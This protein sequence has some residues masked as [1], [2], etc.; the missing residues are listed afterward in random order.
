MAEAVGVIASAITVAQL[1]DNAIKLRRLWR[2]G[3][4]AG[5][6]LTTLADD[7]DSLSTLLIKVDFQRQDICTDRCSETIWHRCTCSCQ[8]VVTELAV[9]VKDLE[10]K[11][12]KNRFKA[13][14]RLMAE[15]DA[16]SDLKMRL[17]AAKSTL[18]MA[19][20]TYLRYEYFL[21]KIRESRSSKLTVHHSVR[22]EYLFQTQSKELQ[23]LRAAFTEAL[24]S[25]S[26]N[27]YPQSPSLNVM[28]T[29]RVADARSLVKF[30]MFM[31]PDASQFRWPRKRRS[32]RT[33]TWVLGRIWEVQALQRS[34]SGWTW[35][36]CISNIVPYDSPAFQSVRSGD[37]GSLKYLLTARRASLFD[38][39][40][41]YGATLLHVGNFCGV[42]EF[43]KLME[44]LACCRVG[45]PRRM[46]FLARAGCRP[47]RSRSSKPVRQCHQH[48]HIPLTWLSTAL[49]YL[50]Y[51]NTKR[52][53]CDSPHN[54][55]ALVEREEGLPA[56]PP[57]GSTIEHNSIGLYRLLITDYDSDEFYDPEEYQKIFSTFLGP[58][59]AFE[60][61]Q[62]H[63]YPPYS[64][65][66]ILQ[67][68]KIA[69]FH[70]ADAPISWWLSLGGRSLD[71]AAFKSQERLPGAA[72]DLFCS[73]VR[74]FGEASA[75]HNCCN[76]HRTA[77]IEWRCNLQIAVNLGAL[78]CA[79]EHGHSP[80]LAF[81]QGYLSETGKLSEDIYMLRGWLQELQ[82]VGVDLI[83]YGAQE[84]ELA[85]LGSSSRFYTTYQSSTL[86]VLVVEQ[87]EVTS[88]TIGATPDDWS[89][90]LAQ[91][92]MPD[93]RNSEHSM[94]DLM[95]S[96]PGSWPASP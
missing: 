58:V 23:E 57:L 49:K 32:W 31:L 22:L 40:D 27:S 77:L 89:L 17:E 55:I 46:R 51:Y 67:Q 96:I 56:T 38:R 28:H 39:D 85:H 13:M 91:S 78:P 33:P 64:E 26:W 41:R 34:Y 50:G 20:Q 24:R 21:V 29:D 16:M 18:I 82:K 72:A 73:L 37:V 59:E 45:S 12:Q 43:E 48:K 74:K 42:D 84:E 36:L 81:F 62:R 71:L 76:F 25:N 68:I 95:L 90:E 53:G 63:V 35:T 79:F 10:A 7:I 52:Y 88:F 92:P 70:G 61:L 83:R 5:K 11:F 75:Y 87:L 2:A 14:L 80:M 9:V 15:K 86:D 94:Q 8:A 44:I 65:L 30:N 1:A 60:L 93:A 3:T 54:F 69:E 47:R 6:E 4:H 66:H 19:Q